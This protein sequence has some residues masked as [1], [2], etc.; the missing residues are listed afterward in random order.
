MT[1]KC[2]TCRNSGDLSPLRLGRKCGK[3]HTGKYIEDKSGNTK[4]STKR[5]VRSE[6]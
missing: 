6:N 5:K 1:I 3:C 4:K 2:N